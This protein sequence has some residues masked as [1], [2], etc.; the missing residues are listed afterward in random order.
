MRFYTKQLQFYCG[1]DLHAN[2]K[3]CVY[4]SVGEIVVHRKYSD[5][6]KIFLTTDQT[7]P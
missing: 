4:D 3:G 7:S 5:Q 2:A 6:T 1:I